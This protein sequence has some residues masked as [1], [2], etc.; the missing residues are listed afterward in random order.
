MEILERQNDALPM[1]GSSWSRFT[2]S[3]VSFSGGFILRA[4]GYIGYLKIKE[5]DGCAS[6]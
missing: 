1:P 2:V 4:Y 5:N 3:G 6:C